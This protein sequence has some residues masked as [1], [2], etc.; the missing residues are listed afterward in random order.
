MINYKIPERW[1]IAEYSQRDSYAW[2]ITLESDD[3][4]LTFEY[5][6]YSNHWAQS[7]ILV[8]KHN[9]KI[10][11]GVNL[12]G[13]KVPVRELIMIIQET[14]VNEGILSGIPTTEIML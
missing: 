1:K 2:K 6:P 13:T 3:I 4:T 12:K 14:F 11:N 9:V 8:K 5:N 10:D 7:S